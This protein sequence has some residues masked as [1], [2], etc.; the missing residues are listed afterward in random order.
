VIENQLD[1]ARV[2]RGHPRL[3]DDMSHAVRG[4]DMNMQRDHGR[5]AAAIRE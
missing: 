1:A 2:T 3:N 4:A 5:R